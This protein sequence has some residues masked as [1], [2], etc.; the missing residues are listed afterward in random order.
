MYLR[1]LDPKKMRINPHT[2]KPWKAWDPRPT[3]N[4]ED[5]YCLVLGK[6][7]KIN[8]GHVFDSYYPSIF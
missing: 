4:A 3:K 7:Y 1:K 5:G 2:N 8:D 6:K